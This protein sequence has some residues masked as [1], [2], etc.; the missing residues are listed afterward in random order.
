MTH[1]MISQLK[2]PEPREISTEETLTRGVFQILPDRESLEERMK[3]DPI[4]LYLGIDPTSPDLHIGHTVPLRVLERFRQRGQNVILLFGTFTGKI[5]DPTDK[6]AARRRLTT[7]EIEANVASYAEQAGKVL[8]LS[9][10]TPNPV[11]IKYNHEWLAKMT[12]ED[13]IELAANFTVQQ[14]VERDMFKRRMEEGLPIWV[15]E[16]LYPFMQGQDSVAMGVD[17]EVGG[18]DQL[19]NM[20]VGRDLVKRYLDKEKWVLGTKLIEDPTGKKMG[21]TEGQIVNVGDWPE[22]KFEG[23]MSWPDS[24]ISIG[25][26]LLTSVSMKLVSRVTQE[27]EKGESNPMFLKEALAYRVVLELDG[28]EAAEYGMEEFDRV[29][30][31][32]QFPS[33]LKEVSVEPRTKISQ[34]LVSSNLAR[35]ESEAASL[36]TRGSV[37]VDG[38]HIRK[39]GVWN[40]SES[41]IQIGKRT[42]R[43]ARRVFTR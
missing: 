34:V 29:M 26:E 19:F 4:M 24:S 40:S 6:S 11:Q 20:L 10:E 18:K 7:E 3:K 42:I 25:F 2:H 32:G 21:K 1:E 31:R 27:L 30:R 39:D 43:N 38:S 5:G 12:F 15:H 14:M 28:P 22:A 17:L 13:V 36:I 8:N 35:D 37:F 41:V 16:L 23:L 33:R 9:Q